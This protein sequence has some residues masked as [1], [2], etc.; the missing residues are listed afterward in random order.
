MPSFYEE[1]IFLC[2]VVER[3]EGFTLSM[4]RV[5]HCFYLLKKIIARF[6]IQRDDFAGT[7]GAS[8]S[9]HNIGRNIMRHDDN[10][11]LFQKI[12]CRKRGNR[13]NNPRNHS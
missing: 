13:R 7:D 9:G 11:V 1:V 8:F 5:K 12:F 10:V 4:M 2:Y 6:C 3:F